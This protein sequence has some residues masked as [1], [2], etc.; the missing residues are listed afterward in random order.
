MTTVRHMAEQTFYTFY[1]VTVC[2]E[3][4]RELRANI[5]LGETHS[6]RKCLCVRANIGRGENA[7][8][9]W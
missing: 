5:V 4:K 7:R 3:R 1:N 6:T 2:G 8:I 9:M